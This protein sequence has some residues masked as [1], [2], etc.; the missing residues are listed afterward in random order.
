MGC[1]GS[2]IYSVLI[3]LLLLMFIGVI[4]SRRIYHANPTKWKAIFNYKW[5]QKWL[6]QFYD[7]EDGKPLPERRKKTKTEDREPLI[8]SQQSGGQ[9]YYNYTCE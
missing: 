7:F 4:L 6:Q 1:V 5:M 2:I 3:T 9:Y 8:S